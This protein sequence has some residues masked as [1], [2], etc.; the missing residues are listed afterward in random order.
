GSCRRY[1]DTALPPSG[2]RRGPASARPTSRP[3][4]RFLRWR[5]VTPRET[6][7]SPVDVPREIS[8][9]ARSE[10]LTDSF[11]AELFAAGLRQRF[12]RL[13]LRGSGRFPLHR[14]WTVSRTAALP[15]PR[16]NSPER[17]SP[18]PG[19][20]QCCCIQVSNRSRATV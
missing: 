7:L 20:Y 3:G 6:S 8:D 17:I 12:R 15:S 10:S 14:V 11:L 2:S 19:G 18:P 5:E 9:L 16:T 4:A 13:C 1:V